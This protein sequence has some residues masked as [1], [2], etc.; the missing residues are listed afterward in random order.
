LNDGYIVSGTAAR[1]ILTTATPINGTSSAIVTSSSQDSIGDL[2]NI[3]NELFQSNRQTNLSCDGL[4][5]FER[6]LDSAVSPALILNEANRTLKSLVNT[7]QTELTFPC[8]KLCQDGEHCVAYI[9]DYNNDRC[10]LL[11]QR[12]KQSRAEFVPL[13]GLAYYEKICLKIPR[14]IQYSIYLKDF[15]SIITKF[16]LIDCFSIDIQCKKDWAFERVVGMQLLNNDDI[17]LPNLHNRME[18]MSACLTEKSIICRSARYNYQTNEC[19]LSRHNRRTLPSAFH[20]TT[21][22]VDYL[23]NQCAPG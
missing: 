14:G 21:D 5:A 7:S 6:T 4:Y 20:T 12:P 3:D 8:N 23:E 1:L 19:H 22:Q 13:A 9:T 18:C 17:I 15:T 11:Y 10:L 2:G 16:Y